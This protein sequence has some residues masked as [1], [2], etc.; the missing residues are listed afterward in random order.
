MF[1]DSHLT[2]LTPYT[3]LEEATR[4][5]T[6]SMPVYIGSGCCVVG[7]DASGLQGLD[8]GVDDAFR[9][10]P[11]TGGLYIVKHGM[12]SGVLSDMCQSPIGWLDWEIKYRDKVIN[13]S[14]LNDHGGVWSR[15][16]SLDQSRASVEMLLDDDIKM[17]LCVSVPYGASSVVARVFLE[18]YNHSGGPCREVYETVFKMR[19]NTSGRE[20]QELY[21]KL[22]F[23]GRTLHGRIDGH[24]IYEVDINACCSSGGAP[25]YGGGRLSLCW[26]PLV[27]ANASEAVF[28]F[29]INE[30]ADVE[31]LLVRDEQSAAGWAGYFDSMA[32]V[33]GLDC[34]EEYLYNMSLYLYR[35]AFLPEMGFPI[36]SPFYRPWCWRASTFWDSNQVMDAIM[37]S[38][39]K[40][41]AQKFMKLLKRVMKTEGR[42]FPW[43]FLYDG[44][45]SIEESRDLAPLAI[46]AHATTAIKYYEYY[47]DD[48][49]LKD[50][51]FPIVRTCADY[52]LE[53]LFGIKDGRWILTQAVSNDVVDEE[54]TEINQTHTLVWFLVVLQKTV[55]YAEI[56]GIRTGLDDRYREVL[57]GYLIE[58]NENEY[59]HS[60]GVTAA[61][62]NWASW[63]P[64]LL[65]PTEAMPFID[66][67]LYDKTREKYCFRE[68]YM[69]KQ[70]SYQPWPEFMQAL[71]DN[72]RGAKEA[73]F[74][75]Y[76][77]GMEHVY[78]CGYFCEIGPR[79]E[80]VGLPPYVSAHGSFVSALLYQFI[81]TDIWEN[82]IGL[83]TSMP[84]YYE[85]R[86]IDIGPVA[87]TGG[88][89]VKASRN[90]YE[91]R[92]DIE[93][94]TAGTVFKLLAPRNLHEKNL[95]VL[96]DGVSAC[97][98][99]EADT[100][101]I[102]I[103]PG[104][105][106]K[107]II[108]R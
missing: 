50:L 35:A 10:F 55:E 19:L 2:R 71:S 64:F 97:F 74:R 43:M 100:G 54:A 8:H 62:H 21:H 16:L 101:T 32:R 7:L 66:I 106:V 73:A 86:A 69:E 13:A 105:I 11:D 56:L 52:A 98:E 72:R 95:R 9:C 39:G 81:T 75:L 20:G 27:G 45:S 18:G 57:D 24:E 14:N 36:G 37:R 63:L 53:H 93:G 99:F 26:N 78:G 58:A 51:V 30:P 102:S 77:S 12:V 103:K 94:D 38:G 48:E 40:E 90:D 67:G 23:D 49:E 82:E 61:G 59:L 6:E 79:Q 83:F 4:L 96:L 1:K 87:C 80:T 104:K 28:V 5:P 34:K 46:A 15:M 76:K 44:T 29:S 41:N 60:R 84:S 22:D 31:S 92:A 88:I 89:T 3:A 65:Y 25:E 33:K 108:V 107:S 91:L 85:G 42:P 17:K 70:G 68:L 47:R